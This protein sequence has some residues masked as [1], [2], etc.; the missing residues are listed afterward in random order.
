MGPDPKAVHGMARATV[1]FDSTER[2]K[3]LA[4]ALTAQAGL[5]ARARVQYPPTRQ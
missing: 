2:H 4:L 5:S 1:T 3:Q